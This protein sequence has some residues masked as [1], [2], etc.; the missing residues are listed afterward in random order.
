MARSALMAV[1]MPLPTMVKCR[2]G[3][4]LRARPEF[5]GTD[6]TCWSC[7][8]A[9]AVPIHVAPG[10]WVAKLLKMGAKQLLEAQ[11]VSLLAIGAALV[12][13]SLQIPQFGVWSAA[14]ALTIVM[15][16]YGELL[17]RGSQG[18]WTRQPHVTMRMRGWRAVLCVTSAIGLTLPLIVAWGHQAQ[19]RVTT[20]GLLIAGVACLVVPLVM[21][22][23]YAP[24][25][26]LQDRMKLIGAMVRRHPFATLCSLLLLPASLIAVELV[27]LETLRWNEWFRYFVS[28]LFPLPAGTVRINGRL[29]FGSVDFISLPT[30]ESFDRSYA[31]GL[32]HGYTFTGSIAASLALP[33]TNNLTP[34]A[35]FKQAHYY[36]WVRILFTSFTVTCMLSALAVQAR[37]L[38]L[39][40]T[41]DSRR[42]EAEAAISTSSSG[43]ARQLVLLPQQGSAV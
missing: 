29:F 40:S 26:S 32:R 13:L 30:G 15:I 5:A 11:T 6:I 4:V 10:D 9:V 36:L 8:E 37:W 41:L 34:F 2:C 42:T 25:G 17:R 21:L 20:P 18:D 27:T 28:D 35:V 33:I 24:T 39:L 16:G 23:T 14:C 31:S 3:K 22:G 7:H 38:G 12:V 19:P 1:G 43:T